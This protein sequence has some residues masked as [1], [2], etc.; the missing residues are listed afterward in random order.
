MF[1]PWIPITFV[2]DITVLTKSHRGQ[3]N[4]DIDVINTLRN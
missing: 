4:Q 3:T 1:I 2:E